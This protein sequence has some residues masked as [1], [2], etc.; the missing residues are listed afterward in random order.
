MTEIPDSLFRGADNIN[1]IVIPG[2]IKVI[3]DLAFFNSSVS[4][5][6]FKDGIEVIGDGA[7]SQTNLKEA[8]LP[9]SIKQIGQNALGRAKVFCFLTHDDLTLSDFAYAQFTK[10]TITNEE[11]GEDLRER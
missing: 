5:V 6:V 3:G 1:G 4:D 7:F 10:N 11:T 8:H 2:N 9:K